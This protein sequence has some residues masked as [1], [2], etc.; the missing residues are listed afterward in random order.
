MRIPELVPPEN[1][2]QPGRQV[3][4]IHIADPEA[5]GYR[6]RR[7]MRAIAAIND[8]FSIQRY[9]SPVTTDTSD[10]ILQGDI[11]DTHAAVVGVHGDDITTGRT[12]ASLSGYNHERPWTN[13][14]SIRRHAARLKNALLVPQANRTHS[15]FALSALGKYAR[16]PKHLKDAD[17]LRKAIVSPPEYRVVA[18]DGTIM[19]SGLVLTSAGVAMARVQQAL[20]ASRTQQRLRPRRWMPEFI[21]KPLRATHKAVRS[22]RA[23][24]T[25]PEFQGQLWYGKPG[26]DEAQ[27]LLQNQPNRRLTGIELIGGRRSRFGRARDVNI[28]DSLQQVVYFDY[29]PRGLRRAIS[30]R[31]TLGRLAT[32]KHDVNDVLDISTKPITIRVGPNH[33]RP[34]PFHVDGITGS[35]LPGQ[36]LQIR[37]TKIELPVLMQQQKARHRVNK[38]GMATQDR[39]TRRGPRHSAHSPNHGGGRHSS[40]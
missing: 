31:R 11:P 40:E 22:M 6:E 21:L 3:H 32:G 37:R 25:A 5:G 16:R 18:A 9:R 19:Q 7:T 34:V 4:G 27:D 26:S 10:E 17:D 35:L 38:H 14:N 28:D 30:L 13:A 29:E 39:R 20:E 1:A 8:A 2:D 33:H 15:H 36:A 24:W 12:I 23:L